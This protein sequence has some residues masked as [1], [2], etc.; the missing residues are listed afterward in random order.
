MKD[1]KYY[2]RLNELINETHSIK[3]YQK[4]LASISD[5][6]FLLLTREIYADLNK[7]DYKG[8]AKYI[9]SHYY[10]LVSLGLDAIKRVTGKTLY[11]PQIMGGMILDSGEIVGMKTGEGK[12]LTAVIP[13]YLNALLK[14]GVHIATVNPYLSKRD[15]EEMKPIYE[16]LGLTVGHISD[17]STLKEKKAEYEKDI[18]YSDLTTLAFDYMYDGLK[19]D[20]RSKINQNDRH[21]YLIVDE[22]DSV[23]ID[24]ATTPFL[25]S[26]NS[27][28]EENLKDDKV[29]QKEK[30]KVEKD[31]LKRAIIANNII[32]SIYEFSKVNPNFVYVCEDNDDY[33][34]LTTGKVK[35]IVKYS[36]SDRE[37]IMSEAVLIKNA[38]T[39]ELFLTDQGYYMIAYPYYKEE[40]S[41]YAS[42]YKKAINLGINDFYYKGNKLVLTPS[43]FLKTV[44]ST[45]AIKKQLDN[46]ITDNYKEIGNYL[47]NSLKAYFNLSKDIDYL[48]RE[49]KK[50]GKINVEIIIGG[51]I[52]EGREF[53]EGLQLAVEL[54]E[55]YLNRTNLRE[56]NL[57]T[58]QNEASL[59]NM[60]SFLS[61]YDKVS[62]MTGTVNRE[63]FKYLYDLDTFE[64]LKNNEYMSYINHQEVVKRNDRPPRLYEREEDKYLALLKEVKESLKKNQPV[65][66]S[67]TSIE[68]SEKV[69]YFLDQELNKNIPLLNANTKKEAEIIAEAGRP[70]MITIATEMAGRGTDIKLGGLKYNPEK[71]FLLLFEK[72]IPLIRKQSINI[73][74]ARKYQYEKFLKNHAQTE[75][76]FEEQEKVKKVGGLKVIGLGHFKYKRLDEQVKGRSARQGDPGETIFLSSLKDL[77]NNELR[78]Y[79]SNKDLKKLIFKIR[80]S[81]KGYLEGRSVSDLIEKQQ[82]LNELKAISQIKSVQKVDSLVD[83]LRNKNRREHDY[84]RDLDPTNL[85]ELVKDNIV[86]AVKYCF[87]EGLYDENKKHDQVLTLRDF[88]LKKVEESLEEHLGL[89]LIQGKNLKEVITNI[90]HLG[91]SVY[92]ENKEIE[93]D[94][95]L[96]KVKLHFLKGIE[97]SWSDFKIKEKEVD[98]DLDLRN[99]YFK[100]KEERDSYHAQSLIEAYRNSVLSRKREIAGNNL[101]ENNVSKNM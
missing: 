5:D 71:E 84:I 76:N 92:E 24:Q 47:N 101:K 62:G 18:L 29:L 28:V 85:D 43:G 32:S 19:I 82:D 15:Y 40:L 21:S 7:M 14:R 48:L 26:G 98:H 3:A 4:K 37:K 45:S 66:I 96:E 23:L 91:Y 78:L 35:N 60:A 59:L 73:D 80:N 58:Y 31:D 38:K 6:R 95:Y 57:S 87:Q 20:K 27:L 90:S 53:S 9:N 55:Q 34:Y 83:A 70:G 100:T 61:I 46:F 72:Q 88:N 13:A 12:T 75:V 89:P 56:F 8:R 30:E 50:N 10:Y 94:S 33:Q 36:G 67:T 74:A 69:K 86:S 79:L 39:N 11:D 49:D 17:E 44:N 54:K 2:Q 68:D 51:R 64:L 42:K 25:I 22:V 97:D 77:E 99:H 1:K 81:E 65:L 63:A 52:A 93:G 16:M 41:D